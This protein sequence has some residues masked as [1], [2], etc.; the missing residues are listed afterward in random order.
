VAEAVVVGLTDDD[1][2]DKPVAFVVA[3]QGADAPDADELIAFCRD[4]LA[5]FKRPRAVVA[6]DELPKTATGKIQRFR[7]RE[8]AQ[9]LTLTTPAESPVPDAAV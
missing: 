2:L 6:V 8:Q 7:L 9:A 4:G 3:K 1:G 5:A